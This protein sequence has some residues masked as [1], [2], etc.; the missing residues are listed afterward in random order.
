M[1]LELPDQT[2]QVLP[3]GTKIVDVFEK[4]NRA[5]LVLGEPGSGKTITLLELARTLIARAESDPTQ[6]IP[7]VFILSTWTGKHKD[8][9][10]WMIDELAVQYKITPKKISRAWLEDC[11]LLLLF[12]GLDEI[13]VE[14]RDACVEAINRF[15]ERFGLSGYVICS[16][17]KE[18]TALPIHLKLNGAICLK[19]LTQAQVNNYLEAGGSKLA[20]LQ[21]TMKKDEALQELAKSPLMLSIMSLAYQD[22]PVEALTHQLHDRIEDCRRHLF[23]TYIE[24]MFKRKGKAFQPYAKDQTKKWLLWLSQK[25]RQHSQNVFFLEQLQPSWLSSGRQRWLYMFGSRLIGGLS[26]AL[27]WM[28]IDWRGLWTLWL[29][30]GSIGGLFAGLWDT[31]RFDRSDHKEEIK[32]A[33][34]PCQQ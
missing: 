25:M 8:F 10:D 1:V 7:V 30:L 23:D 4:M 31:L 29:V 13:K 32:M 22:A 12:D 5:M 27:F 18:Y 19:P 21:S 20:A 16:R 24:R 11:R 33:L 34:A 9:T 2:N 28:L 17:L 6:P 26:W 3:S 15:G 14:N